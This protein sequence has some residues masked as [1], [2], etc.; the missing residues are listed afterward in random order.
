MK[1]EQ[2]RQGRKKPWIAKRD[3][4]RKR[5]LAL[6]HSGKSLNAISKEL[7]IS[8]SLVSSDLRFLSKN[9]ENGV[10][11]KQKPSKDR[12]KWYKAI[13]YIKDEL[14]PYY[15]SR[16]IKPSLR[17][18]FYRLESE[19]LIRKSENDYNTLSKCTVDARLG[20]ENK[21]G[22]LKYPRLPIECFADDTR[23]VIRNYDDDS[24]IDPEPPEDP[25]E[26]IE[27]AI[28]ALKDAP[29]DYSCEGRE[30]QAGGHWY[31]QPEYVEVWEEKYALA[32]T[33][34]KFLEDRYVN[35]VVNKGNSS[36]T[37]IYKN[38]ENLKPKINEFGADH[39]HVLYFGDW[40]PSGE[41]MDE[42]IKRYFRWFGIPEHVFERVAVTLEQ[43]EEYGIPTRR[44]KVKSGK[45]KFKKGED[46]NANNFV[47]KYGHEAA[48][49]DAFL[50]TD[51]IA[52][53]KLVQE[54]VD[55]YYDQSTYDQM[56]E[57]FDGTLAES[58]IEDD[59]D[60]IRRKMYE[61][62]TEAFKKGWEKKD[63]G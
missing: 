35:L 5:V 39:V 18:V 12:Q 8:K 6:Y 13:K 60:I 1:K 34:K 62:I 63:G 37:F 32:P 52:F 56:V 10:S 46:P 47:A 48:D 58:T 15:D 3:E 38:C 31:D 40:D 29:D 28:R 53:E 27:D 61:S 2:L 21:R 59:P 30:G 9:P 45:G 25:D 57:D 42:V 33:F 36:L 17:T 7:N 43:I 49:L 20:I 54:S 26:Y 50:A 16:G 24:P 4:R 55:K 51:D 44:I 41:N 23:E 11:I 22:G 14:L 19:G